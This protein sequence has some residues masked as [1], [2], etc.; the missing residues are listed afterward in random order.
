MNFQI[1]R[2]GQLYGPYTLE[3]LQR[4]VGTGNVLLTDMAKSDDMA[5]WMTVAQVLGTY[6][7]QP[8]ANAVPGVLPG[9]SGFAG[10]TNAFSGGGMY[11]A[12]M[13]TSALAGSPY[14]D[15][16][17]LNWGLLL[18]F[19]AIT[20]GVFYIVY[21]ILVLLWLRKVQPNSTALGWFLGSLGL[22][23]FNQILS[24][25]T[26]HSHGVLGGLVF[27]IALASWVISL[28]GIYS[29]RASLEEHFNT[30]EPVGL[31]LGPVMTF[32]FSGFYFQ[33]HLN[34]INEMKKTARIQAGLPY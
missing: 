1:S 18:L 15:S 2:N 22:S 27:L 3:D 13:P 17:N 19:S 8:G 31:R 5:E 7:I 32:F 25:A 6:G 9:D 30:A 10:T 24:A 29:E 23:I 28:I 11:A 20:C 12:P 4:Y 21:E 26:H 34:R 16:P 33:Y 14:P